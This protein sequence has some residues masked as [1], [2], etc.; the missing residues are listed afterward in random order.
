MFANKVILFQ[1]TQEYWDAIKFC[2]G[3]QETLKLHGCVLDVQ[4]WVICKTICETMFPIVNQYIKNQTW[5]YW[6]VFDALSVT[7]SMSVCLQSEIEQFEINPTNFVKGNF[8][9]E[10]QALRT[11][12]WW[13]KSLQSWF[14]FCHFHPLTMLARL[15]TC[16]RWCWICIVNLLMRWKH[17]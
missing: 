4:T 2:Y 15:I 7:F 16:W 14:H 8:D 12:V 9:F 5:G 17:L 6:L 10:L 11:C 1:K 13:Q 3:R